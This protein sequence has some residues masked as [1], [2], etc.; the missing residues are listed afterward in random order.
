MEGFCEC[1]ERFAQERTQPLMK[2]CQRTQLIFAMTCIECGFLDG[3]LFNFSFPF[4]SPMIWP[5]SVII[6]E[7]HLGRDRIRNAFF[8]L[9]QRE[10]QKRE[11]S[12]FFRDVSDRPRRKHNDCV[13]GRDRAKPAVSGRSSYKNCSFF[14]K[15]CVVKVH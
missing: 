11:Q 1:L 15:M 9:T 7:I 3:E 10:S 6:D 4:F 8:L 13:A 12:K 2:R 5:R 14:S